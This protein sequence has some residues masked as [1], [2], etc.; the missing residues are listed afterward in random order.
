MGSIKFA[1]KN[2]NY[3]FFPKLDFFLYFPFYFINAKSLFSEGGKNLFIKSKGQ[4]SNFS[5]TQLQ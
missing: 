4:I 5:Q 1:L 3:L 2:K